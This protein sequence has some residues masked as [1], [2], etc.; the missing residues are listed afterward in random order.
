MRTR[1][2]WTNVPNRGTNAIFRDAEFSPAEGTSV[3]EL[4]PALAILCDPAVGF[5]FFDDFLTFPIDDTTILPVHAKAVS[6]HGTT[7]FNLQTLAGGVLEVSCGDTDRDESYIEF[8]QGAGV[9][10]APFDMTDAGGKPLFFSTRVKSLE[11][12]DTSIFIGLAEENA[13]A[14]DFLTNDSG[15][16]ADKDLVGFNILTATPAAW[17]VTWK[18]AGQAVQIIAAAAVNAADWHIFS[19]WFDG[20]HTITFLIDGVPNATTALTSAGTVPSAQRLA[21]I[22]AIKT[23]EGVLKRVHSD[24]IRVIQAR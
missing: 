7:A 14:A 10:S 1:M 12:L 18:K 19:F 4:A 20:L 13:A 17:N 21:P 2:K 6:D 3:W 9:L 24:Y 5:Q 23:G 16:L 8:G 11:I 22:I 15:V